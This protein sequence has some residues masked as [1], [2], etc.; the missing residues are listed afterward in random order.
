M[1]KRLRTNILSLV[2][3]LRNGSIVA[4]GKPVALLKT[5]ALVDN[6]R[7]CRHSAV[8]FAEGV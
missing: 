7:A 6:L 5:Q 3:E 2:E 1:K 8:T 4:A